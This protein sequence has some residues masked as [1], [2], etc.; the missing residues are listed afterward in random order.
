M[1]FRQAGLIV[2]VSILV[3]FLRFSSLDWTWSSSTQYP[4]LILLRVSY[5]HDNMIKSCNMITLSCVMASPVIPSNHIF[6]LIA[7]M[8]QQRFSLRS[9]LGFVSYPCTNTETFCKIKTNLLT[10]LVL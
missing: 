6:P 10:N 7:L 3:E 2:D 5:K 8:I 9:K 4:W 1:V